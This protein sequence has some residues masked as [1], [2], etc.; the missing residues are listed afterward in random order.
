MDETRES[1]VTVG[2]SSSDPNDPP[3]PAIDRSVLGEW[4]AGDRAAIDQLLTVF[5]DSIR[6]EQ[7]KLRD[8][9]AAGDLAELARG[10]H[11]LRGAALAMGARAVAETAGALDAAGR[12]RNVAGCAVL[13]PALHRR[14]ERMIAEIPTESSR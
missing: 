8:A 14:I 1:E 4:L 10:A 11:R 3:G 5:R 12:D 6:N 2:G 7:A 13:M 9:L